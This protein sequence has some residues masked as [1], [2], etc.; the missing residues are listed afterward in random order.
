MKRRYNYLAVCCA[1]GAL[2]LVAPA[3]AFAAAKGKSDRFQ[4]SPSG[5]G[6]GNSTPMKLHTSPAQS[7]STSNLNSSVNSGMFN[8]SLST[9]SV[10]SFS[11]LNSNNMSLQKFNSFGAA[12]KLSLSGNSLLGDQS[13]APG[14]RAP[15]PKLTLGTTKLLTGA[16][17]ANGTPPLDPGIGNGTGGGTMKWPG[18][19]TNKDNSK[20]LDLLHAHK[21]FPVGDQQPGGNDGPGN[22][23]CHDKHDKCD[24]KCTPKDK[25]HDHCDFPWWPPI[26]I[27]GGCYH[28][29]C[30]HGGCYDYGYCQAV[31]NITV[32]EQA[33]ANAPAIQPFVDLELVDVRFVDA[34]DAAKNLG[35]RYR[36]VFRNRG[37][38]PVGNFQLLVMA[39]DDG[40]PKPAA[41]SAA[42]EV[43]GLAAGELTSVDVRLPV[44]ADL[45]TMN[46][47][48]VALDSALQVTEIDEQNNVAVLDRAK[49]ATVDAA[50]VAVQ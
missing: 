35:L 23:D 6:D 48:I 31:N 49:I 11:Q 33:A 3:T 44:S 19:I 28:D 43:V 21:L 18:E 42:A 45:A 16:I 20:M 38:L 10:K 8:K 24:P 7:L 32:I 47:L 5:G 29:G 17:Q 30:Y 39:S 12:K 14:R 25:C 2:T 40:T 26:V 1:I 22:D 36:I 15:Q 34:G 37:T 41:P 13:Y 46:A 27:G 4:F 9:K 50:T